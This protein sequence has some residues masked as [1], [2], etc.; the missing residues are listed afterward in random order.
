VLNFVNV[1]NLAPAVI[2][3]AAL[4]FI[5]PLNIGG[6]MVPASVALSG[7]AAALIRAKRVS[8]SILVLAIVFG[9]IPLIPCLVISCSRKQF[10]FVFRIS[11]AP[12]CSK[13][14]SFLG[15]Q[16][17]LSRANY[18]DILFASLFLSSHR[19]R[20]ALP[21]EPVANSTAPEK[22][23]GC[24]G[25]DF[26]ALGAALHCRIRRLRQMPMPLQVWEWLPLNLPAFRTCSFG[27]RRQL[28]ATAVAVA[29][30]DFVRGIIEGHG[31]LHS[32]CVK[33]RDVSAS[34]AQLIGVHPL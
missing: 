25:L 5:L 15:V 6:S 21:F 17:I 19:A 14:V 22:I 2:A 7:I 11:D 29:I 26:I 10:V 13:L 20:F 9:D 16:S 27:N 3:F 30:W 4:N 32:R 8:M 28:P 18:I 1:A 23:F 12:L 34:P 31:D 33:S 24:S